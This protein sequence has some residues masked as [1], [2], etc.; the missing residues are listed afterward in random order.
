MM[1]AISGILSREYLVL[2]VNL[3]QA[4]KTIK[5]D[6]KTSCKQAINLARLS[7]SLYLDTV[8]QHRSCCGGCKEQLTSFTFFDILGD[9]LICSL[10]E[11]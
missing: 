1:R 7:N 3:I 11:S 8:C 4:I 6:Y 2:T 10:A 5:Q 9:V